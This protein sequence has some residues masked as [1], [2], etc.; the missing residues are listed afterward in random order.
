VTVSANFYYDGRM[1]CWNTVYLGTLAAGGHVSR[2]NQF[3]CTLPS[4]M[5][6]Q[7]LEVRFENVVIAQ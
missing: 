2:D 7:D 6:D 3:S 1:I 5:S 4:S